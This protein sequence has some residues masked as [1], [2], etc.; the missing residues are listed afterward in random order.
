MHIFYALFFAVST[1]FAAAQAARGDVI[2]E[3]LDALLPS[4]AITACTEALTSRTLPP[5]DRALLLS[6]RAGAYSMDGK[7]DQALADFDA[8]IALDA[9]NAEARYG[10]GT[11][12]LNAKDYRGAIDDFDAAITVRADYMPVFHN[13]G[14]AQ[15]KLGRYTLAIADFSTAIALEPALSSAYNNRGVAY[16][17]AGNAKR[18][19]ADFNQ[20][21]ALAPR[22][23][24]ALAN[25][26]TAWLNLGRLA[27]AASDFRAALAIDPDGEDA[28]NGLAAVPGGEEQVARA[29]DD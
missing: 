22:S 1:M 28:L 18:A 24:Q 27:E 13:R 12:R 7:T 26:G 14:V 20:A 10:R 25:R 5:R 23:A 17:K 19:L 6:T 4:G 15:E 3:C 21:L 9:T 2:S 8:A 16:R 29:P 11:M